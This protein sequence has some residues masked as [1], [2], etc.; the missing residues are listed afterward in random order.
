[1]VTTM[2]AT[3]MPHRSAA[4]KV[5]SEHRVVRGALDLLEGL[6][7]RLMAEGRVGGARL[8]EVLDAL[9]AYERELAPARETALRASPGCTPRMLQ[10]LAREQ[11]ICAI[12]LDDLRLRVGDLERTPG[13]RDRVVR[14]AFDYLT[15][16]R[17]CLDGFDRVLRR[18]RAVELAA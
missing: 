14:A 10:R 12:L 6:T 17:E 18:A 15:Q 9:E 5:E 7:R 8:L 13:A 4:P 2:D 16:Q 3:C 1:M 11:Q